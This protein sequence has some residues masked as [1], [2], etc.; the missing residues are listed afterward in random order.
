MSDEDFTNMVFDKIDINGDGKYVYLVRIDSFLFSFFYFI[1]PVLLFP[2][3]SCFV[4]SPQRV[5]I[6]TVW[7]K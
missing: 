2:P 4:L 6:A 5:K 3:V 1:V 7:I